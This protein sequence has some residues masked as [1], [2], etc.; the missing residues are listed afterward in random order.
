MDL[1]NQVFEL[2][3]LI[4]NIVFSANFM[5][6]LFFLITSYHFL[7]HFFRDKK[8]I[9]EL[10]KYRDPKEI[11][12]KDLNAIPLVN[13]IIPAWK[14]GKLF[15]NCLSS[16]INLEYPNLK[17]I[18]NAGG[19]EETIKI[20]DSFR[21]FKNF[22]I[23]RQKPEGKMKALNECL[24]HISEGIVFSIDADVFL[25]NEILL[26]ILYPLIN[27]N[28]FVSIGGVRPLKFQENNDIVKFLLINRNLNFKTKFSRY[29]RKQISGPNTCIKYEVIKE[30]KYFYEDYYYS[31]SDRFRGPLI[32]SK[33]FKIYQL[34]DYRGFIYTDYPNSLKTYFSQEIRWRKNT[35]TDPYI[36]NKKLVNIKFIILFFIS[37]FILILPF[38]LFL[39]FWLTIFGI[40]ILFD[41]YLK[42]IRKYMF[43]KNSVDKVYYQKFGLLF[44]IKMIFYIYFEAIITLYLAFDILFQNKNRT[45]KK[46]F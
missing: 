4:S 35:I 34:N 41:R 43:F 28:E 12:I 9:K 38:L 5:I 14:E 13:I 25:T 10:K 24:K 30:I 45:R 19:N 44:F 27:K 16:V 7:L 33:G 6:I 42:K 17:V 21:S 8:Y 31:T 1:I 32:L 22:T 29:G 37:L 18:I 2:F 39:N 26:R 46:S 11:K 15:E 23:L 20:A 3:K 36:E 40:L